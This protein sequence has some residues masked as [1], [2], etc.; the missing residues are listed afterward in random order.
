MKF[1]CFYNPLLKV[2]KWCYCL[3]CHRKNQVIIVGRIVVKK[4]WN[5]IQVDLNLIWTVTGL[6]LFD[7]GKKPNF[8]KLQG[9]PI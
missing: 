7:R 6:L 9:I 2:I 3:G 4:E 8:T 1:F 5:W